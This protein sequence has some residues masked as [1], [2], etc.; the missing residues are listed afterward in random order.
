M[1]YLSSSLSILG[2][3]KDESIVSIEPYDHVPLL[4]INNFPFNT[5]A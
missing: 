3:I 4:V 1:I 5:S 2:S